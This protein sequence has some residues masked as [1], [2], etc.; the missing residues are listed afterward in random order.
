MDLFQELKSLNLKSLVISSEARKEYFN[1]EAPKYPAARFTTY[2]DMDQPNYSIPKAYPKN[3]QNTFDFFP[4]EHKYRSN[5]VPEPVLRIPVKAIPITVQTNNMEIPPLGIPVDNPEN[6][7]NQNIIVSTT[8]PHRIGKKNNGFHK[9]KLPNLR[10]EDLIHKSPENRFQAPFPYMN[11][12]SNKFSFNK[13]HSNYDTIY[14]ERITLPG[15]KES[16]HKDDELKHSDA[17]RFHEQLEQGVDY[18]VPQKE[19]KNRVDCCDERY[20]YSKQMVECC[21]RKIASRQQMSLHDVKKQRSYD[22]SH[23]KNFLK[24]QQKVT[25]MLERIL[26]SRSRAR[27]VEI[28]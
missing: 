11:Q 28:A 5:I 2:K 20:A 6:P 23:F 22:D 25:D 19:Y 27:S 24:S 4:Q 21:Q 9:I 7:I 18:D 8:N 1:K 13:E 15:Y 16:A 3:P 26:A 14:N 12:N 17:P 10:V